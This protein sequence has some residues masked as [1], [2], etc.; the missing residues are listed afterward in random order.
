MSPF[1]VNNDYLKSWLGLY[2][3][4]ILLVKDTFKYRPL[5]QCIIHK[6]CVQIWV[7]FSSRW[8]FTTPHCGIGNTTVIARVRVS[9]WLGEVTPWKSDGRLLQVPHPTSRVRYVEKLSY[10]SLIEAVDPYCNRGNSRKNWVK[11]LRWNLC[12]YI[13]LIRGTPWNLYEEEF[14][15]WKILHWYS[16]FRS[17]HVTEIIN[18]RES[19]AIAA[20]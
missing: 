11:G 14:L 19:G 20:F 16:H 13:P 9:G 4:Y 1:C 17:G 6:P 8:L 5:S 2:D 18:V 10:L 3:T 15:L 12:I 7:T